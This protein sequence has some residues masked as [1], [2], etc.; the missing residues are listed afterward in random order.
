[1]YPQGVL[2]IKIAAPPV[3]HAA[4]KE[5]IK[6][7]ANTL[8]IRKSHIEITHGQLGRNKTV[9]IQTEK[10][11]NVKEIIACIHETLS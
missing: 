2:K 10:Y 1:M 4:N 6:W 11:K 3:D 5:L 7:L 9:T 8:K